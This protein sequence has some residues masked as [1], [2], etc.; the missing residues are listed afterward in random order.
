MRKGWVWVLISLLLLTG[1]TGK[2]GAPQNPPGPSA[3]AVPEGTGVRF[4]LTGYTGAELPSLRVTGADGT[5]WT[6]KLPPLQREG[7]TVAVKLPGDRGLAKLAVEQLDYSFTLPDGKPVNGSIQYRD[8]RFREMEWQLT[9]S[10]RLMIYHV[11][12]LQM[13]DVKEWE[14]ALRQVEE[15][16]G[17]TWDKPLVIWVFPTV[18]SLNDWARTGV[19]WTAA[20]FWRNDIERLI[21]Y[22]ADDREDRLVIMF[23]EMVHAVSPGQGPSWFE[24]GV[25]DLL[26]N[27]F[28]RATFRSRAPRWQY[29]QHA[30]KQL[31]KLALGRP[32]ATTETNRTEQFLDPYTIG[33]TVWMFVKRH[34]GDAGVRRFLK[35]G[36][37]DG[38]KSVLEDL[39]RKDLP[40]IW[41]DWNAYLRSDDLL[42]DWESP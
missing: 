8:F 12:R 11:N 33:V 15:W 38:G 16:T 32:I 19:E 17:L 22:D 4:Q 23:H 37:R 5:D 20:G 10:D 40:A 30:L 36:G 1:C 28:A 2:T 42:K 9:R 6:E 25:A 27:R 34:H 18:K 39:F 21:T 26:E 41:E 13:N 24:E 7:D 3:E 35:D 31:R 14:E 29:R